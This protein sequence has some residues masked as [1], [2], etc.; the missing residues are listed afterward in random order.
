[1]LVENIF[2]CAQG[3]LRIFPYCQFR[4]SF[5]LALK[6]WSVARQCRK[7]RWTNTVSSMSMD[8]LKPNR[9]CLH[10]SRYGPG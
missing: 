3:Q 1:M 6:R 7:Y 2:A 9:S 8:K 5:W 10:E 4:R